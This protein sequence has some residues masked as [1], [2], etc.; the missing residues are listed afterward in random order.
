M[1]GAVAAHIA[2]SQPTPYCPQGQQYS[3]TPS[4][5]GI[6]STLQPRLELA[7]ADPLHTRLYSVSEQGSVQVACVPLGDTMSPSASMIELH[8]APDAS[9]RVSAAAGTEHAG[10][11]SDEF[12][13]EVPPELLLEHA[14]TSS[15]ATEY[16]MSELADL[17]AV[18]FM[19][20]A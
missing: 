15:G 4:G 12:C 9:P 16:Q 10:I 11:T 8:P 2:P 7:D 18:R 13:C 17:M 19:A 20:Q 1:P 3:V 6:G 5:V 14:S